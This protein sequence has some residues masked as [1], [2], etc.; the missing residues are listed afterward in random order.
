[1]MKSPCMLFLIFGSFLGSLGVVESA[2]FPS[3]VERPV[4]LL[5]RL[6]F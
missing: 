1:M 5:P 2:L 6:I 3:A 4:S